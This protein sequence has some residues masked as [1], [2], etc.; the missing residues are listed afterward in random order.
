MSTLGRIIFAIARRIGLRPSQNYSKLG[1]SLVVTATLSALLF[2]VAAPR[3]HADDDR[4]KCRQRIEKAEAQ[5]NTAIERHGEHSSEA[6][7]R[8]RDLNNVRERCWNENHAWWSS[9]DNQWHSERDWDRDEHN[10][11]D[12]HDHDNDQH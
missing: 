12:H 2:F 3:A 1:K 8:R 5:L 10:D 9:R 11:Y 6:Q 7:E 4:D